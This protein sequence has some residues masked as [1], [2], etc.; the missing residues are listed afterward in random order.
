MTTQANFGWIG[1]ETVDIMVT[2]RTTAAVVAGDVEMLDHTLIDAASTTNYAGSTTSGV[3]NIVVPVYDATTDPWQ[4]FAGIFGVCQHGAADDRPVRL[5]L[6]GSTELCHVSGTIV[7]RTS[8][9]VIGDGSDSAVVA[10]VATCATDTAMA[11]KVVFL[12]LTARTGEGTT[13]GWFDGINGFG[14]VLSATDL[15]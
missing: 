13:N 11:R 9:C 1:P 2:N 7:L 15:T 5:R 14:C 8:V 12:P 4:I 10:T 6:R 3:S